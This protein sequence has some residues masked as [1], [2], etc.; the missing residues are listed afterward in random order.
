M[1]IT[2]SK[3]TKEHL[4]RDGYRFRKDI[5]LKDGNVSYRCIVRACCGRMRIHEPDAIVLSTEHNHEPRNN[6][7]E[8][9]TTPDASSNGKRKRIREQKKHRSSTEESTVSITVN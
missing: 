1:E 4:L 6:S 8:Q 7:G 3:R 2:I 9:Q 5:V